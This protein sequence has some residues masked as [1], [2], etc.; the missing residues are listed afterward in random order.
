MVY[1]ASSQSRSR[2]FSPSPFQLPSGLDPNG[3]FCEPSHAI[4]FSPT[5]T[6][7][8][9]R[10]VFLAASSIFSFCLFYLAVTPRSLCSRSFTPSAS[11]A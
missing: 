5:I 7:S 9:P 1:N 6:F 8:A 2:C 3:Q 10:P 11:I 4:V